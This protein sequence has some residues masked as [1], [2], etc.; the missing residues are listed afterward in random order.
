MATLET[1]TADKREERINDG[2]EKVTVVLH[3]IWTLS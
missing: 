3:R 2:V 1:M